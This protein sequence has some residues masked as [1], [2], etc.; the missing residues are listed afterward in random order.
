LAE[1][2]VVVAA[3]QGFP[4]WVAYGSVARGGAL[5]VQGQMEKGLAQMQQ[6]LAALRA[7]GTVQGLP[8]QLAVLAEAYG[9]AGW[10]EEGLAALGP[11][12]WRSWT[13]LG[14]GATRPSCIG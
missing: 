10:V 2:G 1:A 11:R 14:S 13:R 6:G 12:R 5:V 3:E 4:Y 7:I 8:R 9:R